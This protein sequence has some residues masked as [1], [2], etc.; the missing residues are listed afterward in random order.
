MSS[1]ARVEPPTV[2]TLASQGCARAPRRRI[3]ATNS[4]MLTRG[5]RLTVGAI[6]ALG[7]LA[8]AP[9]HAQDS[10]PR[11]RFGIGTHGG[12]ARYGAGEGA[13][14]LLAGYV[15]AGVQVSDLFAVEAQGAGAM[16]GLMGYWRANVYA[17]FTVGRWVSFAVGPTIN[18]G[19]FGEWSGAMAGASARVTA[20]PFAY[21]HANGVRSALSIS[22]EA[23]AGASWREACG[24]CALA[25]VSAPPHFAW[26]IY[27]SLG[28]LRF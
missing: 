27:G 26:G 21:R 9:A 2:D 22:V 4:V 6:V 20:L 11:F 18:A 3:H 5:Q 1:M 25:Q 24:A 13:G 8:A 12:Y 15:R 23:D 28:Y 14:A 16:L 19:A 7:T 17:D 10:A